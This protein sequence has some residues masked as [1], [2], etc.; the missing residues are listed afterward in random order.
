[1]ATTRRRAALEA[2]I[3]QQELEGAESAE[4]TESSEAGASHY[5]DPQQ[6]RDPPAEPRDPP[7]GAAQQPRRTASRGLCLH[8]YG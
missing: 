4:E 2:D 8:H 3:Q 1:M 6:P 5:S 7:R